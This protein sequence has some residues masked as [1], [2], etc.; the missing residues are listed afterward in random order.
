MKKGATLKGIMVV[1]ASAIMLMSVPV[2]A[3][4]ADSGK[5]IDKVSFDEIE[6]L[7]MGRNP[8]VQ[9]NA[10][11][12]ENLI[13][14]QNS[15][16][17]S[18]ED[19]KKAIEAMGDSID[20]LNQLVA[21][22]TA[23]LASLNLDPL[24][25]GD[26]P[27]PAADP[28]LPEGSSDTSGGDQT[29]PG[30]NPDNPDN[31]APAEPVKDPVLYNA[32]SQTL[33]YVRGLYESNISTLKSSRSDLRN[34]LDQLPN[35]ELEV[36]KSILQI[37]AG[38]KNIVWGAQ[39]LYFAYD[40]LRRQRDGILQKLE[41]LDD[42]IKIMEKRQEL[43]M[44]TTLDIDG[45]RLQWEQT[46]FSLDQLDKQME[47]LAGD[48]NQMLGRNFDAPLEIGNLPAVDKIKISQMNYEKDFN[49]AKKVNYSRKLKYYDYQ[50]E[51]NNVELAD[52]SRSSKDLEAA[53]EEYDRT[54]I[55]YNQE[56]R[57]LEAKFSKAYA[58][59]KEKL[60]ALDVADKSLEYAEQ[61]YA[62]LELKYEFGM[63][64]QIELKQG[65]ADY[66]TQRSGTEAAAQDLAKAW[67]QYQWFLDGVDTY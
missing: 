36:G 43:G 30:E 2:Y 35:R 61:K 15:M 52:K 42:Q 12:L 65:K 17:D 55:E 39:N 49:T 46:E 19:L 10:I 11:A 58:D 8:T 7:I 25:G 14:S 18:E 33:M 24:P 54:A 3:A 16:E 67:T 59:V 44:L 41:L 66:D 63:V 64:S 1:L 21:N 62:A 51:M 37:E 45:L 6:S 29:L 4:G 5:G 32:L 27:V 22:Q 31:P 40:S 13:N 34:Q 48:F 57:N 50:I 53:E 28:A 38:N 20:G 56:S 47:G 26:T 60:E 9:I 23:L